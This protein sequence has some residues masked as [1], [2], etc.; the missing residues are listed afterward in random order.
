MTWWGDDQALVHAFTQ[1]L[2]LF[3]NASWNDIDIQ[4][5]MERLDDQGWKIVRKREG[6]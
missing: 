4:G 2:H 5:T 1:S 3:S 6:K